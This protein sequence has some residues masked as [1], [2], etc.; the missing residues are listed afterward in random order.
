M[1]RFG[2][3]QIKHDEWIS[4]YVLVIN[5]NIFIIFVL[6]YEMGCRSS[7]LTVGGV[8]FGEFFYVDT[9]FCSATDKSNA[10]MTYG[11]G[12]IFM[13]FVLFLFYNLYGDNKFLNVVLS[14]L[15]LLSVLSLLGR[16]SGLY[17][18]MSR[19]VM[20]PNRII[21][22]SLYTPEQKV[23]Q[24]RCVKNGKKF[25]ILRP[26]DGKITMNSFGTESCA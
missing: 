1:T 4:N 20:N 26:Q 25:M 16:I 12:I 10:Q 9:D 5:S 8:L 6:I 11:F 14:I 13:M 15:I 7:K 18:A 23:N 17:T 22:P 21:D 24:E 2:K 3:K 19:N